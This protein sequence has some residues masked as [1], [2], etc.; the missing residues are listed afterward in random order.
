VDEKKYDSAQA[1]YRKR[2]RPRRR[3]SL[4]A[5]EASALADLA[6]LTTSQNHYDEALDLYLSA[7]RLASYWK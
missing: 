2:P 4:T 7:L 3:N 5:L 1:D 6:R